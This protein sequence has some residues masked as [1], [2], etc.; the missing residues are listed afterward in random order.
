M[1]LKL[2]RAEISLG[3]I[4]DFGLLVAGLLGSILIILRGTSI[5]QVSAKPTA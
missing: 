4:E 2:K 1:R 5:L 3:M